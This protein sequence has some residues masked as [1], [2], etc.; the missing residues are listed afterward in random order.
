MHPRHPES[1]AKN[2]L[3]WADEIEEGIVKLPPPMTARL[4][5]LVKDLHIAAGVL[6]EH[7]T[8]AAG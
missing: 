7:P 3:D 4:Q 8:A 5:M 1:Q 6:E 2:L